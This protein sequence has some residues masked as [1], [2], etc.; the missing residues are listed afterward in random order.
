MSKLNVYI[1][2][3][4]IYSQS[5][6]GHARTYLTADVIRRVITNYNH[7][8]VN[9]VMNITDV[10]D[11]I[12]NEFSSSDKPYNEFINEKYERFRQDMQSLNVLPPTTTVHVT[13]IIPD[14]IE[15]VQLLIANDYA[16]ESNGSVYFDL[17]KYRQNYPYKQVEGE[18]LREPHS[19]KRHNVDF[20]VWKADSG[21]VSFD[22][23]WGRGLPGW[24]TE[25]ATIIFNE[26]VRKHE[27]VDIHFG[28]IDL[29]FPHHENEVAQLTIA[30]MSHTS[31]VKRFMHIGHLKR[32]GVKMSKSLGNVDTISSAVSRMSPNVYRYAF[33]D[34]PITESLSIS[35]SKMKDYRKRWRRIMSFVS[36]EQYIEMDD[37][38]TFFEE[39]QTVDE[40]LRNLDV[41]G[42]MKTI[43]RITT[44]HT[45]QVEIC[46]F[47]R[48]M[49]EL[50]GFTVTSNYFN[51]V[52]S[53]VNRRANLRLLGIP[54]DEL[55]GMR[56]DLNELH[57]T[58]NDKREGSEIIDTN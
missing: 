37:P 31:P 17:H 9:F 2:G 23:P 8:S 11:K 24:H 22:S 36:A 14:I 47:V 4:T 53:Y 49:L 44:T 30:N 55:D 40:Q 58:I 27:S 5:H 42:A 3:P 28:G 1:C 29:A 7:V 51:V 50:M 52:R 32:D 18:P 43:V 46:S 54:F 34:N 19:D 38:N 12:I 45:P 20:V 41:S 57:I 39:R 6:M 15:F 10:D 33:I 35:D 25:C 21:N 26:F 48:D 13:D 16:Y 56:K